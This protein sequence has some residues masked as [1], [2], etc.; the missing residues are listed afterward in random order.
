MFLRGLRSLLILTSYIMR[1]QT[2]IEIKCNKCG[3]IIKKG[4]LISQ[5]GRCYRCDENEHLRQL[6]ILRWK[7]DKLANWLRGRVG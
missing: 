2:L 7:E 5:D 3:K 4:C 1:K 6:H